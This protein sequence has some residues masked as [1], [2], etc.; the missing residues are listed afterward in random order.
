MG[1][2]RQGMESAK[3]ARLVASVRP[4][5]ADVWKRHWRCAQACLL[6]RVKDKIEHSLGRLAD[7]FR[8]RCTGLSLPCGCA[9]RDGRYDWPGR[10]ARGRERRGQRSGTSSQRSSCTLSNLN[11][12]SSFCCVEL[13]VSFCSIR[14]NSCANRKQFGAECAEYSRCG[15]RSKLGERGGGWRA[16]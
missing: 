11:R 14:S 15:A 5:R 13:P 3:P 4:P 2:N 1:A 9:R 12:S 6:G 8:L 10:A 7:I 16:V